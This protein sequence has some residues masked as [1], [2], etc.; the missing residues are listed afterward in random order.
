MIG[1][2]LLN[3][4]LTESLGEGG[5]GA[6]YKATDRN[7]QRTVAIKLLHP[8]LVSDPAA[9]QRFR[10]EAHLSARIS[11]PN[12][13]TLLDF[14][15]TDTLHFIVMEY[16]EGKAL[17][18][19]LRF[20][21]QIPEKLAV[22]IT[23]QVLEGLEA[24]HE[25]G[26]MHRDLKPG[27]I[28]INKRGFVKL[29]DFGIARLENS[30]RLTQQN[31]VIGTL[32]YL[33]PELIKGGEPS[34]SSDLYA[35]GILLH[36]MLTGRTPFKGENEAAIMYQIT[37]GKLDFDFSQINPR[38]AQVIRKLT[39]RQV[40]RRF[41]R[42]AEVLTELEK[43]YPP[44]K[45]DTKV[46]TEKLQY[47]PK[48][49]VGLKL[50]K[51]VLPSVSLPDFSGKK[52][53]KFSLPFD[54]DLRILG[55][56]VLC[57]LFILV[58]S[59]FRPN[60]EPKGDLPTDPKGEIT[61]KGTPNSLVPSSSMARTQVTPSQ[62]TS[63]PQGPQNLPSPEQEKPS[64]KEEEKQRPTK[65]PKQHTIKP[66]AKVE[67]EKETPPK[68]EEAKSP[69]ETTQIA[70][71]EPEEEKAKDV[72]EEEASTEKKSSPQNTVVASRRVKFPDL[73][74]SASLGETVSTETHREGQ[75]ITLYSTQPIYHSGALI[76]KDKAKLRAKIKK[77]RRGKGGK[78]AFLALELLAIETSG[79]AWL[80]V[81][82]PE[83][84]NLNKY[85]VEFKEGLVLSK[86]K[87]KSTSI[88]VPQTN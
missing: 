42:T 48:S 28:M 64:Q 51:P 58:L 56:A 30:A 16:V 53:P 78:K 11:H 37:Q 5:M 81:H 8:N 43:L 38:L 47:S 87:I 83:Y 75:E 67:E 3:F 71:V 18:S 46:L 29:M 6:V 68:K 73:S 57:C 17:D 14:Q 85:Q 32:E 80:P 74:V 7:L 12:V 50:A 77:L 79:G 20:Q 36:E 34:R 22:R 13:A 69:S 40:S 27:N 1:K 19:L 70:K 66:F 60:E 39:H 72:S 62:P 15:K 86:I 41:Q 88:Y 24:A 63:L 54:M 45:I 82:Y 49:S 23:M 76:I 25:M 26:I 61:N 52:V 65:R 21:E 55:V 84:S 35:L 33:A 2:T 9:F 31:R 10:N 44:G 59:L 4:H